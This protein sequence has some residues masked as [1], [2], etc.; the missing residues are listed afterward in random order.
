MSLDDTLHPRRRQLVRFGRSVIAGAAAT[1]ADLGTLGV[2]IGLVGLSA[3]QAN[4]PALLVGATVQFIGNRQFA[5]ESRGCVK[6][7]VLW[8]ALV[9][10]VALGLNGV[11][12]DLVARQW[13]LDT[14]GALLV[15][16]LISFVVFVGWSYPLFRRIFRDRHRPSSVRA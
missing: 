8:F 4:L 15:R 14:S 12:Y 16:T 11:G 13:L 6:R 3:R 2:A 1:L 9:E 5:F 7:Q 10:L